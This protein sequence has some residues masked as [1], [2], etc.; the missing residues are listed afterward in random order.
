MKDLVVKV[1][2]SLAAQRGRT[3]AR[4]DSKALLR[5]KPTHVEVEWNRRLGRA[6]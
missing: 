4:L 5:A 1:K 6:V 2:D 3:E